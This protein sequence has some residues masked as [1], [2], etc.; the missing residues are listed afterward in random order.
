M[1]IQL[2]TDSRYQDFIPRA[3]T[4]NVLGYDMK[5]ADVKDVLHGKIWA[6]SDKERRIS[7]RQKDLADI[8]RLIESFPD[9]INQLSDIIRKKIE[10]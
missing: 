7:K 3:K 10:L 1:R 9:L 8:L 4:H 2:Q 6:Y 5:V